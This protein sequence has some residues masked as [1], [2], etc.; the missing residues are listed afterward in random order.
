[1]KKI[2]ISFFTL[3]FILSIS[4][5]E[6]AFYVSPDGNDKHAGTIKKPFQTIQ[7][8]QKEIRKLDKNKTGSATVFIREG[9][10]RISE[11]L[12]FIPE[13]GGNKNFAVKYCNYQ[14][15]K[16][17]ISGGKTIKNW[18][19]HGKGVYK[20]HV[21]AE[22]IRNLYVNNKPAIRSRTPNTGE[23]LRVDL[24]DI[25]NQTIY[26]DHRELPEFNLKEDVEMHIHLRW[27]GS[28]CR[29]SDVRVSQQEGFSPGASAI[30]TLKEPEKSLLFGRDYPQKR[31][32]QA[33]HFENSF[34]F[35][36]APNEFYYDKAKNIL[37]YMPE[38][39]TN[40]NEL[41]FTLPTI[42]TL[43]H[44]KGTLDNPVENI[45]F[46]GIT[47]AHTNWNY[48]DKNGC[49]ALEYGQYT[50]PPTINNDQ[51]VGRPVAMF[52]V[53]AAKNIEI[54]RNTFMD[55]GAT[56]LDFHYGTS[57]SHIKGNVFRYISGNGI[58]YAKF[59]DPD[60]KIHTPYNPD[61]ERE[62]SR[63]DSITNNFM[64]HIGETYLGSGGIMCGYPQGLVIAHNE[65]QNMPGCGI[66]VGW[67]W[68]GEKSAMQNNQVINNNIHHVMEL[69]ED[70][71]AIKFLS[72]SPNSLLSGNWT[73]NIIK[74]EWANDLYCPHIYLDEATGGYTI[75]NNAMQRTRYEAFRFHRIGRNI[76]EDC[77]QGYNTEIH[78]NAGLKEEYL[79]IKFGLN[80]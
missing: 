27:S 43:V 75:K 70:Q 34:Q 21:E 67:G 54:E 55:G 47:F 50:I 32:Q 16:P 79:E 1:M 20:T 51:Y 38:S 8:A 59:S 60:V 14:Q 62:I 52:L 5:Q 6:H 17:I 68:T 73:H 66:A 36:D 30:I 63:N 76:I 61:D 7:R 33:F 71:G 2:F 35:L 49:L 29:I 41:N 65:L 74:S 10:F 22:Y 13:D 42:E 26:I 28:I 9:I 23:F 24:W 15:E 48:P 46:H 4:A 39:G 69:L 37:Y 19:Y 58:S 18:E 40:I 25:E 53:E 56:A 12:Y 80:K 31:S 78:D 77:C 64:Q 57:E 44:V 3:L 11:P 72:Y 45:K